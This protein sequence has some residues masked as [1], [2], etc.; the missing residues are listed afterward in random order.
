MSVHELDLPY[1]RPPLGLNDRRNRY[2][3]AAEVKVL[4]HAAATVCRAARLGRHERVRVTLHY[5]PGIV[6]GRKA[7]RR[8]R[9]ADNLVASS[10]PCAD[11]L[12]DAGLVRDDTPEHMEKPTPVIHAIEPGARARVWLVVEVLE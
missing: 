11:G 7:V 3:H 8:G 5:R 2:A 10:K 6:L 4:R 1:V 12:V 9:D